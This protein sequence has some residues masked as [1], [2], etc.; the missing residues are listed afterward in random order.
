[1]HSVVLANV[2]RG[3][4]VVGDVDEVA[5]EPRSFEGDHL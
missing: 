5:G 2:R 4:L 3:D 1:M